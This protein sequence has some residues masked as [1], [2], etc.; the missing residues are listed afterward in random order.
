[1]Y[2]YANVAPTGL[3][4]ETFC[5]NLLQQARVMIFPGTLFADEHKDHIRVSLLAPLPKMAEAVER[6]K[7]FVASL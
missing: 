2:V 6:L 4:S 1:M 5:L 3:D 7:R